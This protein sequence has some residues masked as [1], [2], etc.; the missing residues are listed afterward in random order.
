M[1]PKQYF[2]VVF[3]HS[4]HCR[5]RRIHVPHQAI[6]AVLILALIGGIWVAGFLLSYARMTWKVAHYNS[7]RH[8][9]NSL[10]AK[11]R[12]LQKANSQENEQLATLELF[13]SQVSMAYGLTANPKP[14]VIGPSLN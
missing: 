14:K 7:L 11:Y 1:Q 9:V 4:L 6:Y 5:L 12:E 3:A 8:E 13:A 2:V 10:R